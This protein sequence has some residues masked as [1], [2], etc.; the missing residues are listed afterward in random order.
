[1]FFLKHFHCCNTK[2]VIG[3]DGPMELGQ[4][5]AE[6]TF[7]SALC[8]V[9]IL[10]MICHSW[11][12]L[13][14]SVPRAGT[15]FLSE[16]VEQQIYITGCNRLTVKGSRSDPLFFFLYSSFAFFLTASVQ[17][18]PGSRT[19]VGSCELLTS[20]FSAFISIFPCYYWAKHG[21]CIL[22]HVR[23]ELSCETGEFVALWFGLLTSKAEQFAGGF[24]IFL[25]CTIKK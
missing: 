11:P 17:D 14:R 15:A 6:T 20:T 9:V 21:C 23:P 3:R 18:H 12:T 4:H 5:C 16:M 25:K 19:N 22:P 7:F 24:E 2:V 13:W 10:A 8:S 1:M